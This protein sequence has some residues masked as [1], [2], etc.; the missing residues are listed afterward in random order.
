MPYLAPVWKPLVSLRRAYLVYRPRPGMDFDL[1]VRHL[2]WG[3]AAHTSASLVGRV[4]TAHCPES[5]CCSILQKKISEVLPCEVLSS[6][7][8]SYAVGALFF[9]KN[10]AFT[11]GISN[12]QRF[13]S[14]NFILFIY[15]F[16]GY[17]S[18]P[19]C[20]LCQNG[21]EQTVNIPHG[22]NKSPPVSAGRELLISTPSQHRSRQRP[23]LKVAKLT[24]N[25]FSL[26]C[27]LCFTSLITGCK[28]IQSSCELKNHAIHAKLVK[29]HAIV[30]IKNFNNQ[31]FN[32]CTGQVFAVA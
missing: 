21:T 29:T 23:R 24:L 7:Y 32:V 19:L 17:T 20:V 3:S 22:S 25:L 10:I 8:T 31:V 26:N 30:H 15:L 18:S 28:A 1:I 13:T 12:A 2:Q 5:L 16:F 6:S 9:L 27:S 11:T 4:S 14:W